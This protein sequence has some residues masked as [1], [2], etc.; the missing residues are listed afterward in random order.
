M[1]MKLNITGLIIAEMAIQSEGK[2]T[3]AEVVHSR[4]E[5]GI[6]LDEKDANDFTEDHLEQEQKEDLMI[7]KCV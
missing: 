4:A 3:E 2:I 6:S 7:V 1:R 5:K